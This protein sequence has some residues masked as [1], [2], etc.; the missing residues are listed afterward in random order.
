M[1][2]II[3]GFQHLNGNQL[4]SIDIETTGLIPGYHEIWQI[5]MIPLD[6]SLNPR[7]DVIP[8]YIE[9][10]PN[11]P[12]HIDQAALRL[13]RE[14]FLRA[15]QTGIDPD[16]AKDLFE[17]W[18]NRLDLPYDKYGNGRRKK[19]IPLG[20]NYA[21]FDQFFIRLWLEELYEEHFF[22]QIRDTMIVAGYLNDYAAM[23]TEPCPF[24]K[25]SL[26]WLTTHLQVVLDDHHDALQD[27]RATAE[28]YKKLL[29]R[30]LL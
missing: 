11:F 24:P 27:A 6:S 8:F 1:S 2:K 23:H 12:E 30:G 3:Y 19:I 9:M 10:K 22:G 28:V 18:T 21:N 17:E 25:Y 14:P 26:R 4:C 15:C 20:H 5:A 16:K 29:L 7:Q 13:N